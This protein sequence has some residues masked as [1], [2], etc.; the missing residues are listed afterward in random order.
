MLSFRKEKVK[1]LCCF[2]TYAEIWLWCEVISIRSNFL[3]RFQW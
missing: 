2:P 1:E 3:A